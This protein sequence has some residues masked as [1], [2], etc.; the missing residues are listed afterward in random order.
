MNMTF[1]Q[2]QI[3]YLLHDEIYLILGKK[4]QEMMSHI[5]CMRIFGILPNFYFS[6]RCMVMRSGRIDYISRYRG[7]N[8]NMCALK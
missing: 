1:I 3:K 6:G 5:L 8:D 7:H 2:T 4:K